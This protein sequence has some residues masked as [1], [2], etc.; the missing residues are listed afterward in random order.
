[1]EDKLESS[2]EVIHSDKGVE[3]VE[4]VHR[5]TARKFVVPTYEAVWDSLS[6]SGGGDRTGSSFAGAGNVDD[7]KG[8]FQPSVQ[9]S[10][11]QQTW[12]NMKIYR[13]DSPTRSDAASNEAIYFSLP[14]HGRL[15]LVPP[16]FLPWIEDEKREMDAEA[17]GTRRKEEQQHQNPSPQYENSPPWSPSGTTWNPALG[18]PPAS[19][20]E[21]SYQMRN[22]PDMFYSN[23]WD[24]SSGHQRSGSFSG[25][26]INNFFRTRNVAD[27]RIPDHLQR[28]G[29]FNNL[30]SDR[31]NPNQ[32]KAVFPW[33]AKDQNAPMRIFADE[34][35]YA[36]GYASPPGSQSPNAGGNA[37]GFHQGLPTNLS[38]INAWDTD[39]SIGEYAENVRQRTRKMSAA[40]R[41]AERDAA[42]S[43]PMDDT[44]MFSGRGGRSTDPYV[45]LETG[46]EQEEEGDNESSSGHEDEDEE[47]SEEEE[48]YKRAPGIATTG[49]R[50]SWRKQAPS[51][52]YHRRAEALRLA[53]HPSS[54]R[55]SRFLKLDSAS[56]SS[57]TSTGRSSVTGRSSN[58]TRGISGTGGS[59]TSS[60]AAQGGTTAS[61]SIVGSPRGKSLHLHISPPGS[62]NG[63]NQVP[64]ASGSPGFLRAD[65]QQI[66]RTNAQASKVHPAPPL[67]RRGT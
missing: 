44:M 29:F 52:E 36:R 51:A 17:E 34:P 48:E 56:Q 61:S 16:P 38:Y 4:R 19:A 54:P 33:E 35:G 22:A 11:K 59:P 9:V 27:E 64:V 67:H 2:F 40:E 62:T 45:E 32:V 7:L 53:G 21:A 42:V 20:G 5:R 15:S 30:G 14:I 25:S 13:D 6:R 1:M 60:D 41:E 58:T 43:P 47:E 28:S 39:P 46:G 31:P 66:Q 23:A 18:P 26:G 10:H 12:G 8:M 65:L 49:R 3:V 57:V 55:S 24:E 63:G 37:L 50:K